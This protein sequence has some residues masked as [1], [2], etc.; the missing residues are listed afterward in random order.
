VGWEAT[1]AIRQDRDATN[2]LSVVCRGSQLD[3]YVNDV[4]VSELNDDTLTAGSIG[5]AA[6]A[7]EEPNVVIGFD[8]LTVY[9][10][11]D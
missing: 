11:Q 6:G 3:F 9:G 10:L 5:L 8:N 4:L 2:R 7:F 1:D